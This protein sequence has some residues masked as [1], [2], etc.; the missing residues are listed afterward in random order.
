LLIKK[1]IIKETR[2]TTPLSPIVSNI[3]TRFEY[4][5]PTKGALGPKRTPSNNATETTTRSTSVTC[6]R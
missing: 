4:T 3:I 5:A 6:F 1:I 2:A